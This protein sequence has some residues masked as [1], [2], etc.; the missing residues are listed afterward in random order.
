MGQ[1]EG[2][3]WENIFCPIFLFPFKHVAKMVDK[4]VFG[5]KM[6]NF[7][8]FGINFGYF[9]LIIGGGGN[10]PTPYPHSVPTLLGYMSVSLSPVLSSL[11]CCRGPIKFGPPQ[12]FKKIQFLTRKI[13]LENKGPDRVNTVKSAK[14]Q[15]L[16][17]QR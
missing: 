6:T 9:L 8:N 16:I 15:K 5:G 12:M 10:A 7:A 2:L 17:P 11:L 1:G 14:L 13:S 4:F 3:Q